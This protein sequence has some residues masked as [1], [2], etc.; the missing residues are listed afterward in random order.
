MSTSGLHTF[1]STQTQRC[2]QTPE[3]THSLTNT[4]HAYMCNKK[5]I[6]KS[7]LSV[8]QRRNYTL[9]FHGP[10]EKLYNPS[11]ARIYVL[12]L[13]HHHLGRFPKC[14]LPVSPGFDSALPKSS[15]ACLEGSHQMLL[16]QGPQLPGEHL[17]LRSIFQ[18]ARDIQEPSS[19]TSP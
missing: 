13:K 2:T 1:M 6:R 12:K 15:W 14:T 19:L 9:G 3:N 7:R 17:K 8:T 5:Q 10:A 16:L 11:S 4:P 18:L